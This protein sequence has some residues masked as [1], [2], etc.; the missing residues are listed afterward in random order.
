MY[1]FFE[2][3]DKGFFLIVSQLIPSIAN[4]SMLGFKVKIYY[5][6]KMTLG[7]KSSQK[8]E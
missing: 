7:M 5:E 4:R 6:L 2:A 8:V 1:L 3:T